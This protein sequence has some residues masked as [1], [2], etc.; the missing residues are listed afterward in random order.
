MHLIRRT[1][2]VATIGIDPDDI[3][4]WSFRRLVWHAISGVFGL[5]VIGLLWYEFAGVVSWWAALAL[6]LTHQHVWERGQQVGALRAQRR[7]EDDLAEKENDRRALA[8]LTKLTG[9]NIDDN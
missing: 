5:V 4:F 3:R 1:S 9:I 6:V 8:E 2:D 7:F